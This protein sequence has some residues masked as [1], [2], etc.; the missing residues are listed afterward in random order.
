MYGELVKFAADHLRKGCRVVVHCR[1]GLHRSGVA[2]YLV[3]RYLGVT[4][5]TSLRCMAEMRPE[6]HRQF[7]MKAKHRDLYKKARGILSDKKFQL[8]L[9][10]F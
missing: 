2:I 5:E 9:E 10:E 1:Q 8:R 3:L 6:M 7:L 4:D